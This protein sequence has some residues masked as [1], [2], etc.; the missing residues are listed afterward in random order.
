MLENCKTAQERWGGRHEMI[1]RWLF[2]RQQALISFFAIQGAQGE[3][4]LAEQLQVFSQQLVDY[5]SEG[6]FEIYEQLFHEAKE[7]DDGGLEL[8]HDLYPK[9]EL[10]T[11]RLLNFNDKYASIELVEANI[12]TLNGDLSSLGEKMNERFDMEDQLIAR[13]HTA[14]QKKIV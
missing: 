11:Q 8:A 7:F 10:T 6:H 5:I 12:A 2:D 3:D 1:D 13:L 14:H 9:I 4:N